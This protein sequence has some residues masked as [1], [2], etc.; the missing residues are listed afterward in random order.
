MA[1][2]KTPIL[3]YE[4]N[5]SISCSKRII[6]TNLKIEISLVLREL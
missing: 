2:K 1:R 4:S 5:R 3:I 6:N